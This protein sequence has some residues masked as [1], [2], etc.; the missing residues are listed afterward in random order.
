MIFGTF[1]VHLDFRGLVVS[2]C[3]F[4]LKLLTLVTYIT[5]YFK[6]MYL[7]LKQLTVTCKNVIYNIIRFSSLMLTARANSLN[8]RLW[9]RYTLSVLEEVKVKC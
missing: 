1:R 8:K 6:I 5:A 3:V 9:H 4:V 7:N 2:V